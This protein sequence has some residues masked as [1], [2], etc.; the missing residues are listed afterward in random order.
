M[1]P[2]IIILYSIINSHNISFGFSLFYV[3]K[4]K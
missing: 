4:L 1:L 2:D 3:K